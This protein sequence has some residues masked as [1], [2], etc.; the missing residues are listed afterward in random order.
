MSNNKMKPLTERQQAVLETVKMRLTEKEAI[1]YLSTYGF[2]ISD[3]TWYREKNKLE[4]MKLERLYHIAKFRFDEQHLE[5]IDTL[6]VVQKM[7]WRNVIQE[8]DPCKRNQILKD[9][10]SMQQYLS[11]Y[12]ETTK[13]V[14]KESA[15]MKRYYVP[16][17]ENDKNVAEQNHSFELGY[18]NSTRGL[19]P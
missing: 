12:Y 3:T 1:K 5:R 14:M 18:K 8:E 11:A 13:E 6:E 9:I 4:K 2:E 15:F 19:C 17:F 7:M 16:E 10:V